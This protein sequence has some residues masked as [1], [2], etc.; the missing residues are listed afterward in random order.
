M[1]KAAE[2]RLAPVLKLPHVRAS[3]YRE[4]RADGSMSRIEGNDAVLTF[5]MNDV[6]IKSETMELV[7]VLE[8]SGAYKSKSLAE[9]RIR[10]DLVAV[11]MPIQEVLAAA[12]TIKTLVDQM[13]K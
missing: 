10:T 7:E 13:Q 12:E 3:D 2:K 6:L 5:F 11:R 4:H 9:D 8:G 1:A